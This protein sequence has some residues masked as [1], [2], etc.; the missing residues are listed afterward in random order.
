[1]EVYLPRRSV[2]ARNGRKLERKGVFNLRESKVL[3]H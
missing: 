3:M 2:M 1:M